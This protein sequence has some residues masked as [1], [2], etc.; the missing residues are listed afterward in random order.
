MLIFILIGIGFIGIGLS[1][2]K[3]KWYFLIAGYNTMPKEKQAN[4]DIDGLGRLFGMYA[5]ANGILF[6]LAGILA[7][8]GIDGM[9]V[10]LILFL[11]ISTVY[12]VVRAQKYDKNIYDDKGDLR[13]GSWKKLALPIGTTVALLLIVSVFMVYISR[14]TDVTLYQEGL[15]IHGLYGSVYDWHE[16]NEVELRNELPV[17]NKR[18]NGSAIGSHL[19]GYFSTEEY[20]TVKLFVDTKNAPF[21]FMETEDGIVFFNGKDSEETERIFLEI[22]HKSGD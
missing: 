3:L 5:Y 21:I 16:I 12:L 6:V 14:P 17:I 20:G 4:V 9:A 19:K 13:K 1:V 15:Q 11:G 22:L 8:S 7:G 18:T 2:H 10:P